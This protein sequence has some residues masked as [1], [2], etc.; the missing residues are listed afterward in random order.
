MFEGEMVDQSVKASF[1]C[2]LMI[3]EDIIKERNKMMDPDNP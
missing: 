3:F 1:A 2:Y